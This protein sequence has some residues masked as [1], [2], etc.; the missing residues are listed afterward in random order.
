MATMFSGRNRIIILAAVAVAVA[1]V[2]VV[3]ILLVSGGS[4]I[5]PATL[6]R[7]TET[8]S[9]TIAEAIPP[10]EPLDT[11][12]RD[13]PVAEGQ[14]PWAADGL[15]DLEQNTVQFLDEIRRDSPD[16]ADALLRW[17][18][19]TDELTVD[20]SLVIPHMQA[21][22]KEDD[23]LAQSVVGLPWLADRV[24]E[25]ELQIIVQILDIAERDSSLA[26]I[27]VDTSWF[28]DGASEVTQLTLS[29]VLD[30]GTDEDPSLVG[31]IVDSGVLSDGI[32]SEELATIT[33]TPNYYL[34]RL[35]R[36]YPA[37]AEIVRA[38]PW[39]SGGINRGLTHNSSNGGLLAFP[40]MSNGTTDLETYVI[41]II[42]NIANLDEALSQRVAAYPWVADG[43]T[44]EEVD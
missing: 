35:E 33:G 26:T 29:V 39:A 37:T 36:E 2:V 15:N 8:P 28:V 40:L 7:A 42:W 10:T 25:E 34:D 1:A 31:R 19:L 23:S 41:R 38:Y 27:L 11:L 12:G 13:V 17:S 32:T 3:V 24:S 44:E 16:T 21:I 4:E 14:F 5:A 43:V 18:W 6:P 20:E 9:P 22:A 30:A